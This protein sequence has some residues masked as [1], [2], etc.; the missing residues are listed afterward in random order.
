MYD[1]TEAA[2]RRI[3]M[4]AHGDGQVGRRYL[5]LAN[6]LMTAPD[7]PQKLTA[8]RRLADSCESAMALMEKGRQS[9]GNSSGNRRTPGETSR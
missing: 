9:R 5:E 1:H 6:L 8:L 4:A 3:L 2:R 7:S